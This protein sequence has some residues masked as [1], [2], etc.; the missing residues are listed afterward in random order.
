MSSRY[1]VLYQPVKLGEL[2]LRNR[3]LFPGHGTGLSVDNTPD[4]AHI[5]YLAT[6]ARGGVAL[7]V[8]EIAQIEQRAVYSGQALRIVS[9]KQIPGYRRL[10]DA[11]HAED[12]HVLVQIFHPGREMHKQPDGRQPVAWAPSEV[13]TDANH[14]M[15][16]PMT[17]VEIAQTIEQFATAASRLQRAGI[18]GVEIVGTHGFLPSQFLNPATNSRTDQYGGDFD[19]R[20][21]FLREVIA[22]IR[23]ATAS[24]F[25]VGLRICADEGHEQGLEISTSTRACAALDADGQLDYFSVTSGTVADHGGALG[26]IP[27]MGGDHPDI[28]AQARTIRQQVT[29]PVI[30]TGRINQM[31]A[32]AEMVSRGDADL[33]GMVRANICDPEITNKTHEG[34]IEDVRVCIGCNQACIG[35]RHSGAG[36]S[37]IQNPVAG[38][39]LVYANPTPAPSP[40]RL[41]VAGGGPAG[42]KAAAVAAARGHDVVLYERSARLGGQAVLA[43]RLPRRAEFGGLISNLVHEMTT[44][45]VNVVRNT[46]VDRNLVENELPDVVVI[47]TGGMP[48]KPTLPGQEDAH[49]VD[50]WSVLRGEANVGSRVVVADWACD[51]IGLGIAEMLARDGCSVRLT[52]NGHM[53]GEQLHAYTRDRWVGELHKLGV[54]I[55][56]YAKLYGADGQS[57]YCQHLSSQQPIVLE[58]V[59]TLVTA[60]GH[61]GDRDLQTQLYGLATEVH[62][63]GDCL[64]ARSAEEAIL[65]G[66]EL[67]L[68]I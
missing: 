33:I 13:P 30:A 47:A 10:A 40:R 64:A 25:V 18:D 68:T 58:D 52:V 65:E 23:S 1:D 6:R 29:V 35:H 12:S 56:P 14:V 44:A 16:K 3:L 51:W 36:V 22:G 59:D 43:E 9:D 60:L 55:I 66:L 41:L 15:P 42:M 32:A 21:R 19:N 61:I 28:A 24:P 37:C 50:A 31:A 49:I 7:V 53:A 26:M 17:V 57:V 46:E 2:T 8:T 62:A 5:A 45:G 48:Y 38:R 39:E 20:M 11:I 63:I 4:D 27:P 34:R 67:A 54:E